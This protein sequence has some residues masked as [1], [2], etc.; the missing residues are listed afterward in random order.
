M[1]TLLNTIFCAF[2]IILPTTAT[3]QNKSEHE[4]V[5][6][7]MQN[8]IQAY[9]T[10]DGN[11]MR[12]AFRSDGMMIGYTKSTDKVTAVSG[13]EFANRFDGTLADDEA[14]RKRS[15]K[16]LDITDNG[17]MVKVTLDYPTWSGVDYIA[18]TKIDGKWMIVS[19][20]YSGK[21]KPAQKK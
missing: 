13:E 12:K 16:I 20:S 19:K 2:L 10:G 3:A 17:A 11:I 4:A 21:V 1:K 5:K 18:L 15:F 8:F 6:A 14:Q 9:E 7:T